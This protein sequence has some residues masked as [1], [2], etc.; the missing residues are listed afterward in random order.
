LKTRHFETTARLTQGDE[1]RLAFVDEIMWWP[2]LYEG[3]PYFLRIRWTG[4]IAAVYAG[5][6]V[7]GASLFLLIS[8]AIAWPKETYIVGVAALG[9]VSVLYPT[10]SHKIFDRTDSRWEE[11]AL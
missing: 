7:I 1:F 10:I 8:A 2:E 5:V 3:N 6:A 4:K 11:A 9:L